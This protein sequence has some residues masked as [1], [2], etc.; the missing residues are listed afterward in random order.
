MIKELKKLSIAMEESS[1]EF[2]EVL[3][4]ISEMVRDHEV[5]H[6]TPLP[7]NDFI[8]VAT[9]NTLATEMRGPYP[10]ST[11]SSYTTTA[12]SREVQSLK[13]EINELRKE[14]SAIKKKLDNKDIAGAKEHRK[15]EV[16][17]NL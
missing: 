15:L 12:P 1:R 8:S 14:L 13:E 16:L 5:S 11:S 3:E 17:E 4:R 2:R 10:S 9:G 7:R 6:Y